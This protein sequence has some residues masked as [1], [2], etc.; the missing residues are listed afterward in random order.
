MH[1]SNAPKID[2]VQ[3]SGFY[4]ATQLASGAGT[5]VCN[6]AGL[7]IH[8]ATLADTY[9]LYR[10]KELEFRLHP[11]STRTAAQV[12]AYYPGVVDTPP[13]TAGTIAENLNR[14]VLGS[15]STVPTNWCKVDPPALQGY[16]PWYKT[17]AGT[18][19]SSEEIQGYIFLVGTGTEVYSLELRGICEFKNPVATGNTPQVRAALKRQQDKQRVLELLTDLSIAPGKG[20]VAADKVS[21]V[22]TALGSPSSKAQPSRDTMN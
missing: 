8:L 16:L 2:R 10:I 6:P 21:I 13:S 9:E 5:V 19:D 17:I 3:W 22:S 7:S 12:A 4:A 18:L 15:T 1:R 20:K 14:V 11:N